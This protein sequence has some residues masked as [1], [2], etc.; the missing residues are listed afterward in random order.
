MGSII[1]PAQNPG[2]NAY[3]RDRTVN[4]RQMAALKVK[5]DSEVLKCRVP[6]ATKPATVLNF[7]PVPLRIWGV[8]Y[9]VP[10]PYG[11]GVAPQ[12]LI[13]FHY[14]GKAYKASYL[15]IEM[16]KLYTQIRDVYRKE[17]EDIGDGVGVYDVNKHQPIEIAHVFWRTHNG[18]GSNASN[19]GGVVCWEGTRRDLEKKAEDGQ[20]WL[21]W[22]KFET[23]PDTRREYYSEPR[24][25]SEALG[26]ALDRQR[27]Y[28]DAHVQQADL[29]YT[30]EEERNNITVPH[31]VWHQFQLDMGWESTPKP[32]MHIQSSAQITCDGCGAPKKRV[33]AVFCHAC[34][35]PFD[36]L[37]AYMRGELDVSSVH[38]NRI[39]PEG[40]EKVRTEEKR[41]RDL[42]KSLL[43]EEDDTPPKAK[44]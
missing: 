13:E 43:E 21:N 37:E 26:E 15:T 6:G 38:M 42:R 28:C 34:A 12:N 40:W 44:K 17:S 31:R 22:P 32:W 19:M 35:R 3:L 9:K 20:I 24:L 39:E 29:Y 16:P 8:D 1:N 30:N 4:G 2:L 5:Y 11:D 23:L 27:D 25:L 36:P 7:N 14:K 41:R 33:V 18:M 10:S